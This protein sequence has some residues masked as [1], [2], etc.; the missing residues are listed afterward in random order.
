M[1]QNNMI[2]KDKIGENISL[3]NSIK[4]IK[5]QFSLVQ[6]LQSNNK[7]KREIKENA[8]AQFTVKKR[9]RMTKDQKILKSKRKRNFH[10]KF[11][12]DNIKKK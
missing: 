5:I 8:Y 2:K 11:S 4:Q 12:N 9:G 6:S 1:I 3:S 10:D 7:E